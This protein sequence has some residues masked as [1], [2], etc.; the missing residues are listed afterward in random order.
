[1]NPHE[2]IY[3]TIYDGCIKH[4]NDEA[5]CEKAANVGLQRYKQQNFKSASK[6]VEDMVKIAEKE[7]VRRTNLNKQA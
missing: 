5:F 2:F 1:M 3:K 4:L 6:L 7:S